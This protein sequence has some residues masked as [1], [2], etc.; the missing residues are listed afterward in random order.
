MPTPP[1]QDDGINAA[2]KKAAK[3]QPLIE[4]AL[5]AFSKNRMLTTRLPLQDH[6]PPSSLDPCKPN[7]L[8]SVLAELHWHAAQPAL[9]TVSSADAAHSCS[10]A[11]EKAALVSNVARDCCVTKLE[12]DSGAL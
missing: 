6:D 11:G 8:M 3:L 12:T 9:Q 1:F 4:T 7:P 2:Q 5:P 10:S